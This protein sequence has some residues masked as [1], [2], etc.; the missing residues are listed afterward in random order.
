MS[1][2]DFPSGFGDEIPGEDNWPGAEDRQP[3]HIQDS[4]ISYDGPFLLVRLDAHIGPADGVRRLSL[5]KD[6]DFHAPLEGD[7]DFIIT[8][9]H[10]WI[11]SKTFDTV[12]IIID[13]QKPKRAR[14]LGFSNTHAQAVVEALRQCLSEDDLRH[15]FIDSSGPKPGL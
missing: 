3:M 1:E 5:S 15:L 10:R 2:H 12:E 8:R 7:R 11:L 13:P 14:A 6:M 4:G 9:F